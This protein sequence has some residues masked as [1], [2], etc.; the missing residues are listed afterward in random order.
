MSTEKRTLE[1]DRDNLRS[2]ISSKTDQ[3]L[4]LIAQLKEAETQYANEKAECQSLR[5]DNQTLC[6]EK[7]SLEKR[8]EKAKEYF[9]MKRLEDEAQLAELENLKQAKITLEKKLG[10]SIE[11]AAGLKAEISRFTSELLR[12]IFP[13]ILFDDYY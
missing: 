7:E 12:F 1:S 3:I 2:L 13:F 8:L 11:E 9:N 6:R 10:Q 4:A 5:A